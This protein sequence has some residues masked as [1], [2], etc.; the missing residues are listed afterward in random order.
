ME[1]KNYIL[2]MMTQWELFQFAHDTIAYADKYAEGI[3]QTYADKLEELRAAFDVY[4]EEVAQLRMPSPLELLKA[5]DDRDYAIRKMYDLIR[6][7]SDYRFDVA[8]EEAGKKLK[9]VFKNYGTGSFISRQ[10]QEVQTA[11]TTLLLQELAREVEQ[12]HVAILGLNEVVEALDTSNKVFKDEQKVRN[13]LRAKY[14]TGVV[15]SV[16]KE[17]QTQIVEFMELINALAVVEGEE[18]YDKLKRVI[19]TMTKEYVSGIRLRTKKK[20]AE[21]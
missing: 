18:K 3:P 1:I 20:E 2:K 19:A 8:K 12:Q 5:D 15:Q 16:R 13:N 21:V 11:M 10:A 9:R 7:Y 4:D 14:V 6:Y 17:L